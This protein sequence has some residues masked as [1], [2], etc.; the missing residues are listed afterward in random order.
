MWHRGTGRRDAWRFRRWRYSAAGRQAAGRKSLRDSPKAT[1]CSR[2]R[3][4]I[5]VVALRL[6]PLQHPLVSRRPAAAH[7][8]GVEAVEVDQLHSARPV[9]K[10]AAIAVGLDRCIGFKPRRFLGRDDEAGAVQLEAGRLMPP[11]ACKACAAAR[12][13]RL[14]G[15]HVSPRR[16]RPVPPP[17]LRPCLR[18]RRSRLHSPGPRP[19]RARRRSWRCAPRR[20]RRCPPRGGR[21]RQSF[22]MRPAFGIAAPAPPAARAG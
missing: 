4:P 22:Q 15:R 6:H 20:R 7:F 21:A 8:V 16:A 1:S 11:F 19:R 2:K 3:W 5:V 14:S 18:V 13:R 10:V 12:W 17:N 9:G